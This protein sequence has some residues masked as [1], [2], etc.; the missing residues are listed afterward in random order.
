VRLE[1]EGPPDAQHR[2]LRDAQLGGEAAT[3]PARSTRRWFVQRL[4]EHR[5]EQQDLI[6]FLR[7]L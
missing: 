2:T 7:S 6:N 5:C 1:L 4:G 3:A